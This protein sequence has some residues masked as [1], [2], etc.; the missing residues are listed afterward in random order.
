MSWSH[1]SGFWNIHHQP[2]SKIRHV[3]KFRFCRIH[4]PMTPLCFIYIN[5]CIQWARQLLTQI[6]LIHTYLFKKLSGGNL[7]F[8]QIMKT[9]C[10]K[11]TNIVLSWHLFFN[12]CYHNHKTLLYP[13]EK[14]N[15]KL[16]S[17]ILD[18]NY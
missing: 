9:H 6:T 11:M 13:V 18:N 8:Y 5:Q 3:T 17:K 15:C 10:N 16:K 7:Y 12:H 4:M 1:L 2:L 14:F